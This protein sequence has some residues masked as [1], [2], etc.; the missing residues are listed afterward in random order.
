MRR[1]VL[2]DGL[3]ILEPDFLIDISALAALFTEYGHHPLLY[4]VNRML[5]RPN[6][7]AILLGNFASAALDDIINQD[8]FSFSRTLT[9]SFREQALQFCTCPDFSPTTF[10]ND[11][12]QQVENLQEVVEQLFKESGRSKA[13][14]EPSF[15]CKKLG[16]R[17]RVDLMTTDFRLLVEQ[18]S[19]K[20]WNKP[21]RYREQHYVQLLLYYGVLRYNFGL[22][23]KDIKMFLLYSRYKAGEGLMEV[24]FDETVFREA[25]ALRNQVVEL[26]LQMAHEGFGSVLPKLNVENIYNKF[27][28]TDF[29][30]RYIEPKLTHLQTQLSALNT[31]ERNY[32]EKQMTFVYRE[33]LYSKNPQP[34]SPKGEEARRL[35]GLIM[36]DKQQSS[37][38]SGYDLLTLKGE[39]GASDFRRGDMICLY[40]YDQEPDIQKSLLYRGHLIKIGIEEV[41]IKLN[42]GQQNGN[43]FE[44]GKY[45][46]EHDTSDIGAT[47]AIRSLMAFAGSSPQKRQLLL[48]QRE[49]QYDL[50]LQLTRSFHPDYDEVVLRQ[51]QAKDY[52]LLVGPP[53]TGKTSM[54]LRFIV[55]EELSSSSLSI[56]LMA[57]TNRAVDE[58][59]SMLTDVG[60]DFLRLGNE[61]SCDPRFKS[62]LLDSQLS[63]TPRLNTIQQR[64]QQARVVVSTT[65]TMLARPFI[66]QLKHFSLCVVD[67]ASQILEPDIIGLLASEAINRFVLIGDYKQLPAVVQQPGHFESLFERLIRWE[68][69]QGRKQFIGILRKQGRMHPDV[70]QFVNKM[71]YVKEQLEP[72]PCKHQLDT[73]LHYK[74]PSEDA[75]DEVLK[76]HRVVFMDAGT[77]EAALVANLLWRIWRLHDDGQFDSDKTVGII[78]P[79]RYQI[80]L[81]RQELAR[82]DIPALMQVCIDTVERYQGSQRDVI[83]Y[84]FGVEQMTDLDFLTATC[85]E[86]DGRIIDRKLNVALTRARKQLL[87]TGC[88]TIL[89]HNPLFAELIKQYAI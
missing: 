71:F 73:S 6:S 40:A 33:Q 37:T 28:R 47:S 42:D 10:K 64:I 68:H 2:D 41:V 83:I 26:E 81:I 39:T 8:N 60:I 74:T 34:T 44:K 63:D 84:S 5:P 1:C 77:H 66:F 18:K 27:E 36:T 35:T 30:K 51:K 65:T 46:L 52:Y 25:I 70:A 55:E 48:G 4:T 82:Y 16:L 62:H 89:Q 76:T 20:L 45:I 17:G 15:V 67:E 11:A 9:G 19:G 13:V 24:H 58:I 12:Q 43:I 88:T 38:E 29:F 57:Y 31:I 78:V 79:Y 14:L 85:F 22:S 72:V 53:G 61:A 56:L 59:C 50:T 69:L 21:L 80:A 87:I 49:P 54:A 23:E 86:E 75:L 3:E 32:I 7:Q